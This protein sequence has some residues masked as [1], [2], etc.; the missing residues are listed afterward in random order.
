MVIL[1]QDGEMFDQV[2]A[3]GQSKTGDILFAISLADKLRSM[4]V[5][6]YSLHPGAIWTNLARGSDEKEWNAF[7]RRS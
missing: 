3:Y 7:C 2:K 4:G 6:G 5:L 1:L